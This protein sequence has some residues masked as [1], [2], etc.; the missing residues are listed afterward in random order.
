MARDALEE[1]LVVRHEGGRLATD[2]SYAS[3]ALADRDFFSDEVLVL[4]KGTS[5]RVRAL[6]AAAHDATLHRHDEMEPAV[7][8][9][10]YR[11][12][13]TLDNLMAQYFGHGRY[14]S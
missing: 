4:P 12:S 3:E 9:N 14:G 13:L 8:E 7:Q 11:L 5:A 1:P 10:M 2:A 6:L